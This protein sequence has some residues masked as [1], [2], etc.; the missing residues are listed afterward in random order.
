MSVHGL[1]IDI[2]RSRTSF[3]DA[4]ERVWLGDIPAEHLECSAS[5]QC[6]P[7]SGRSMNRLISHAYITSERCTHS[8]ISGRSTSM[9][10]TSTLHNQ[11]SEHKRKN[12]VDKPACICIAQSLLVMPPSTR[13]PLRVTPESLAMA[14]RMARV[15]KHVASNVARAMSSLS[16]SV[17]FTCYC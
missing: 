16:E 17:L 13:R 14:S 10:M 7:E 6:G 12:C 11:L 5:A 1:P 15:W 9:P 2:E 4:L 8:L 3:V